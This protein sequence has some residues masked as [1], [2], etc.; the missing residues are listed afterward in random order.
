[1]KTD[2]SNPGCYQTDWGM[3]VVSGHNFLVTE[4]SCGCRR[5]FYLD[6]HSII[7]AATAISRRGLRDPRI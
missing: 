5:P 1:M 2:P 7:L 6:F 4:V 3:S